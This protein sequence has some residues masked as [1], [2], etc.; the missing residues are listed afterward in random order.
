MSNAVDALRVAGRDRTVDIARPSRPPAPTTTTTPTWTRT[1]RAARSPG[2]TRVARGRPRRRRSSRAGRPRGMHRA[3]PGGPAR[4]RAGGSR[5]AGCAATSTSSNRNVRSNCVDVEPAIRRLLE[6]LGMEH[7][8]V[9]A[10]A[11]RRRSSR[12]A[13]PTR[14]RRAARPSRPGP[15]RPTYTSTRSG[16]ANRSGISASRRMPSNPLRTG[17][18]RNSLRTRWS[19][20]GAGNPSCSRRGC[21]LDPDRLQRPGHPFSSGQRTGRISTNLPYHSLFDVTKPG[22]Y[23][24]SYGLS[25]SR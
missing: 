8:L 24:S 22:V 6:V 2:R 23:W 11:D 7:R 16:K 17:R 3:R 18:N 14:T 9:E 12:I 10:V 19:D 25:V 4:A 15:C 13:I 20:T 21:P 1:G 5:S